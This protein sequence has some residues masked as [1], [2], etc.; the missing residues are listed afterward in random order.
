MTIKILIADDHGILRAGLIALLNAEPGMEVI[1]E[2]ETA[3]E[4]V[5]L[6][7]M[8][9]PDLVL[10]DISMPE[11]G[12]IQATRVLLEKT[13]CER[14]LILTVHEDR[15]LMEDAIRA[16]ASGY[17]LKSAVTDDLYSAIRT[18]M[19]GDIYLHPSMARLLFQRPAEALAPGNGCEQLTAREIDVLRLLAQGY[20]NKQAA[21][22]LNLSVRTV[23]FHRANITG[24]LNLH[25]RVDLVRYAEQQG[26]I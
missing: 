17:L 13:P 3:E 1:G 19:H 9:N 24:K 2:A 10:M 7:L 20:T 12:G 22:Q 23:E 26:M 8:K 14:V 6:T 25:S 18:V 21:D 5:A 15:G 11:M 16:G 4:A